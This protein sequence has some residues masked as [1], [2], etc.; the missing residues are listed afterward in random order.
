MLLPYKRHTWEYESALR[1][2]LW[3]S[4]LIATAPE[5][6]IT[7]MQFNVK[8]KGLL[9]DT[10]ALYHRV[11]GDITELLKGAAHARSLVVSGTIDDALKSYNASSGNKN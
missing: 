3:E 5:D 7:A 9:G 4:Y 10:P 2:L 11:E 1:K 6:P 8:V